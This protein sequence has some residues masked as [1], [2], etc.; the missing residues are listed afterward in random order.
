MEI[1]KV[2]LRRIKIE[3]E[4]DLEM[5]EKLTEIWLIDDKDNLEVRTR[6]ERGNETFFCSYKL[7]SH[8]IKEFKKVM[9]KIADYYVKKKES[10]REKLN[11]FVDILLMRT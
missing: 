1:G 3:F 9:E 2:S 6:D 11:T 8:L 4:A 5:P 7:P 10:E